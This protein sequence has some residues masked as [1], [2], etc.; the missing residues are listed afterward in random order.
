LKLTH[1]NAAGH[2]GFKKSASAVQAW[3]YWPTWSTDLAMHIK[4]CRPCSQYHRGA[5]PRHAEMQTPT[6]GE[7]WERISLDITG[8]HPKSS[9]QNQYILTIVDHFSKWAEAIPLP[10]HTAPTVARALMVNVISQFGAP[11]QLL[12]DRGTEFE[13]ELFSNLMQWLGVEKLRTTIFKPSTNGIVERFHR[14]LN[15]LLGKAVSESQRNWDE[16]LPFVMAAY[17]SSVH[18]S[19]GYSPNKLFLG[20][21]S[22]MP[23]DLAMGLPL[24][25]SR[26]DWTYDDYVT[27]QQE[28][29]EQSYRLVREHL[30]AA[31]RR[32]KSAYDT[33]VR[34]VK[35]KEGDWVWYH[36]PRR[37]SRR[38]P[39]WQKSFVGPFLVIRRLPPVNY[40]L[41]KSKFAKPF[42]VHTDKLKMCFS[43]TPQPWISVNSARDQFEESRDQPCAAST[44]VTV[45]FRGPTPPRP[46]P[47]LLTGGD[48]TVS[49]SDS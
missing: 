1:D 11:L 44:P 7:P 41:Q 13:S 3:A 19:T 43:D 30:Q 39:K 16:K 23:V 37:Y 27:D 12:T 21:E 17:R 38:T 31:S 36:Y 42:V 18:S 8:P 22:R 49:P 28:S 2:L 10:N 20:R 47:E 25:E 48:V 34:E 35:F 26:G 32:R 6:A 15:S 9:K 33:R 4:R 45:D 46:G 14:T 5:L 29:A 24:E 40:V